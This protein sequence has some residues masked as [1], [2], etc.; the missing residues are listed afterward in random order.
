MKTNDIINLIYKNLGVNY[1]QSIS[2]HDMNWLLYKLLGGKEFIE[3]YPNIS[4]YYEFAGIDK[5]IKRMAL[6]EEIADLF[7]Q[8][9]VY[10]TEMIEQ[11]N[12]GEGEDHWQ[13]DLWI[14]ARESASNDFPDKTMVGKYIL[15]NLN[16]SNK[17]KDRKS[18]RLNS[19]HVAI[20]YA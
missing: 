5:D 9:Q 8:Y 10:R 12:R 19:S 4:S 17:V 14:K 11:W 3:K 15:E 18:T 20:S 6:A 2:T 7:D 16:D 1:I 13:K